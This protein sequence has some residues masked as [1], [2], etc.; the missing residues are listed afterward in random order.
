[1]FQPTSSLWFC[2][3]HS[4][5]ARQPTEPQALGGTVG[6][7]VSRVP[8]LRLHHQ[9]KPL[10]HGNGTGKPGQYSEAEGSRT[11]PCVG[12]AWGPRHSVPTWRLLK[13]HAGPLR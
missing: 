3:R 13:A 6:N 2:P 4:P 7:R 10:C 1:M 11:S 5:R 12:R 8:L 9:N